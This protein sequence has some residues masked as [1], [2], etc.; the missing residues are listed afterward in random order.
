MRGSSLALLR[1]RNCF[2]I[3]LVTLVLSH[4]SRLKYFLF[5]VKFKLIKT[6]TKDGNTMTLGLSKKSVVRFNMARD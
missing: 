3:I 5:N 6:T 1:I 4:I 2:L